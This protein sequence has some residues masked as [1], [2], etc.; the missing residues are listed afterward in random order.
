MVATRRRLRARSAALLTFAVAWTVWL[1]ADIAPHAQAS[2][3]V[4]TTSLTGSELYEAA[5]AACHGTDGTGK[6]QATVGFD[7]RL[8][9]FTD[10][11]YAT[12]EQDSDWM[13]IVAHGG[14]VRAFDRRMPAFGE[15]LSDEDILKILGHIRTFCRTTRWPRGEL[16]LPRP[17]ITE[18]AFPENEAVWTIGA[19]RGGI[20]NEFVYERRFGSRTQFEAVV[21]FEMHDVSGGGWHGGLGDLAVAVK[22]VVFH[23][24]DRGS[25]VSVGGELSAPTG[26]ER[27]G[28][29]KG[30]SVVEPFVAAGQILPSNGF[31]HLQ[32]GLELPVS[33]TRAANE[34]FWRAAAGKSFFE[35]GVGRSWSPMIEV[36]GARE[37]TDR[38][39]TAWDLVPQ[40]QV[41]LSKRQHIIV[42]A[43][44]RIPLNEREERHSEVVT[45]LLWDW[46]DGGFLSGWR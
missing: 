45:Y 31:L 2:R 27:I 33:R 35:G 9:D 14:P 11:G 10:C 4:S 41:T 16:N 22:G 25:I 46:F 1:L 23:S 30:F 18:K 6:P 13:A 36:L 12:P 19:T 8:P 34:A 17:L 21:P 20:R 26:N 24:L 5:C 42:N 37:L 44:V 15:A 3:E 7:T 28:L 43:G 39:A 32:A 38:T 29:G 40:M